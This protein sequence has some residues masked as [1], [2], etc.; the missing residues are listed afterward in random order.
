VGLLQDVVEDPSDRTDV[1]R[2]RWRT[3]GVHHSRALRRVHGSGTDFITTSLVAAGIPINTAVF[4]AA[5]PVDLID[6]I[7]T[8]LLVYLIIGRISTRLLAKMPLGYVYLKGKKKTTS[9]KS[10][11]PAPST[12]TTGA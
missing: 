7:P 10:S 6:K 8:V 2:D 5:I 12:E 9:T 1:L 4:L 3:R 11:T